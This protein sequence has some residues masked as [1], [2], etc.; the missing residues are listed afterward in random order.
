M[1]A[2]EAVERRLRGRGTAVLIPVTLTSGPRYP[3]MSVKRSQ[4]QLQNTATPGSA[5]RVSAQELAQ[6]PEKPPSRRARARA[7]RS[8]DQRGG[9]RRLVLPV[10]RQLLRL[11][12]SR[13]R[14]RRVTPLCESLSCCP[15]HSL[16]HELIHRRCPHSTRTCRV[17]P[18]CKPLCRCP[19]HSLQ[20]ELIHRHLPHDIEP[21]VIQHNK[22]NQCCLLFSD[23]RQVCCDRMSGPGPPTHR[24]NPPSSTAHQQPDPH[25][26]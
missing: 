22:F 26:A 3:S 17:A 15:A 20:R 25:G 21:Q 8:S 7:A 18:L 14:T 12:R 1:K 2:W 10:G 4:A 6:A 13:A 19:A 23:D 11:L 24:G 16:E 9:R 5:C